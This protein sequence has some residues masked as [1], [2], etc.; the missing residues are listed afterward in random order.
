MATT[1]QRSL[2]IAIIGAGMSG[3]LCAIRLREVGYHDFE[4]YEKATGLG[5]TWRDN[6]YPGLSCDI[7]SHVY[8][9]SFAPNPDWTHKYSPGPEICAYFERI[10]DDYGI[11]RKVHFEHEITRC[12]FNDNVWQLWSND[13]GLGQFDVVLS[14][15]GILHHPRDVDFEG[16]ESFAGEAFH[17]ARWPAGLSLDGQRVGIIGNGSTS[18]QIITDVV[19][20][21]AGLSLFQRTAQWIWPE[22]NAPYSQDDRA[23][24]RDDP[25]ML[26]H[27]RMRMS[28]AIDARFSNALVDMDSDAMHALEE[29]CRRNLEE[30]VRDPELRRKLT[31][32]YRAGCKR[33]IMSSGFYESIQ[34]PN[35]AVVTDGIKRIEP[36]GVR[37]QD[38]T[39][40]ELD[41]LVLATGFN[42]HQ[43]MRPMQ[44]TGLGGVTL[45]E[46][47]ADSVHAYQSI[48]M[49]DFPNFFMLMG[50]QSPVGNFSLIDVAEI[51]FNY[52]AQLLALLRDNQCTFVRP[53]RTATERFTAAVVDAMKNTIWVTGCS[54]WYLDERGVPITW[55]WTVQD[56]ADSMQ[57][58]VMEDFELAGGGA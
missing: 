4:I 3:I 25:A 53:T 31:P 51:Q 32:D 33:L 14:A 47:W 48:C 8:S 9:Y 18:V 10:A 38:G 27:I 54:S 42:A 20:R 17:T 15:T 34:H 58:I 52:I 1:R 23:R 30:N 13:R 39:L 16:L 43:F 28:E 35:A 50:P 37:T 46:V 55:P 56:F 40:H 44:I 57:N 22:A 26:R 36:A 24:F 29:E 41:V 7:P 5:G 12:E 2:R 49:P 19:E 6:R 11:R 21:V 45:E